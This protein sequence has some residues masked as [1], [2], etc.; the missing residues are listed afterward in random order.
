MIQMLILVLF[1][2]LWNKE[3]LIKES[4]SKSRYQM[5]ITQEIRPSER[6]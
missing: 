4:M 1:L 5:K 2:Y 6:C 3:P